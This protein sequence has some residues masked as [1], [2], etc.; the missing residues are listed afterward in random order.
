M[1]YSS[2]VGNSYNSD[3]DNSYSSDVDNSYNCVAT[4]IGCLGDQ[5]NQQ[6]HMGP[7]GCC[8]W[9]FP[10]PHKRRKLDSLLCAAPSAAAAAAEE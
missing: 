7:G 6:A 2:D 10:A 9:S 3:A 4:C 5:P 1:S 8:A